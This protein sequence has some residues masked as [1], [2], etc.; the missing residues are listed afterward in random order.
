[1]FDQL[2]FIFPELALQNAGTSLSRLESDSVND[3]VLVTCLN[4]QPCLLDIMYTLLI[5]VTVFYHIQYM[6]K[7]RGH[8]Q[9]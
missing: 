9:G 6:Y 2:Y 4:A 5:C 7:L 3:L 8:S 1:M